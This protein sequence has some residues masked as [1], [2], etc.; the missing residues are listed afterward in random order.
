M[1]NDFGGIIACLIIHGKHF[2]RS[3][4][5]VTILL[6]VFKIVIVNK[7]GKIAAKYW[8]RLIHTAA[9]SV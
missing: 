3:I 2:I 7:N 9:A 8:R 6:F 4:W 5:S 1:K